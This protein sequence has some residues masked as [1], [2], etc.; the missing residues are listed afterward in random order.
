MRI[1]S[2]YPSKAKLCLAN[3]QFIFTSYGRKAIPLYLSYFLSD[4]Q[5]KMATVRKPVFSMVKE[6][7]L[8][9]IDES[10]NDND[11]DESDYEGRPIAAFRVLR[12]QVNV[13]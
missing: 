12:P 2:S 3:S 8:L 10:Q 11:K 13:H 7:N 9:W 1:Q 4:A 6:S 5:L